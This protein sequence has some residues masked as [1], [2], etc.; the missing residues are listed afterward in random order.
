ME[1]G[2]RMEKN[3]QFLQ[4]LGRKAVNKCLDLNNCGLT[5]TDVR[6]V[7]LY[8]ADWAQRDPGPLRGD[9]QAKHTHHS[10]DHPR[11]AGWPHPTQEEQQ[12]HYLKQQQQKTS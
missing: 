6:E 8:A 12:H 1:L 9:E 2:S 7:G 4:K 11:S 3:E 5:T 10:P